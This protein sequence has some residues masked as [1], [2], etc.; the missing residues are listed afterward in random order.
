MPS[1]YCLSLQHKKMRIFSPNLFICFTSLEF[2]WRTPSLFER[3][4]EKKIRSD[5]EHVVPYYC[6]YLSVENAMPRLRYD[7]SFSHLFA[8]APP[9]DSHLLLLTS[10]IIFFKLYLPLSCLCDVCILFESRVF[11][12]YLGFK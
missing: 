10:I 4:K 11:D 9:H 1:Q 8:F 3:I 12:L 6:V 5:N 7:F 2:Q